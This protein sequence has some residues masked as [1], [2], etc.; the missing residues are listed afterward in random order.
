MKDFMVIVIPQSVESADNLA[1]LRLSKEKRV[2]ALGIADMV[3][4]SIARESDYVLQACCWFGDCHDDHNSTQLIVSNLLAVQ[5]GYVQG[6]IKEEQHV[7]L[8]NC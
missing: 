8:F 5:V 3:D 4:S 6:V 2:T 7:I 1:A